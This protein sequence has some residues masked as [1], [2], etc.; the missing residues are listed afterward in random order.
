MII[1]KIAFFL[2]KIRFIIWGKNTKKSRKTDLKVGGGNVYSQPDR[3]NIRFY[4]FLK[5]AAKK[6]FLGLSSE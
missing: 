1:H 2:C 3:K 6:M 4:D 5:E